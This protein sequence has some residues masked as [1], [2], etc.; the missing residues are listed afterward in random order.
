MIKKFEEFIN[1]GYGNRTSNEDNEIDRLVKVGKVKYVGISKVGEKGQIV[2]PKEARSGPST[3]VTLSPTP[4]VECLSTTG[5]FKE[6]KS[7]TSPL[8]II[9]SVKK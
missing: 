9:T 4:P 2:I 8:L 6:D 3:K 5:L 7:I 1:E